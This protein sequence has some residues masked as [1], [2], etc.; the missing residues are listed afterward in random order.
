MGG[1][2]WGQRKCQPPGPGHQT[3]EHLQPQA[4]V[5]LSGLGPLG[6]VAEAGQQA[7]RDGEGNSRKRSLGT[8]DPG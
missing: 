6:W 8:V 2:A 1:E 4:G 7:E 5:T 3:R